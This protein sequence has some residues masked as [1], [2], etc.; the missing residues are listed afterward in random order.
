MKLKQTFLIYKWLFLSLLLLL[1]IQFSFADDD[2]DDDDYEDDEDDYEDDDDDYEDVDD[3][4]DSSSAASSLG[5]PGGAAAIGIFAVAGVIFLGICYQKKRTQRR[6]IFERT[7]NYNN[8]FAARANR[9]K[10]VP[11]AKHS[12]LL[13]KQ[14][15]RNSEISI[16]VTEPGDYIGHR[17]VR[18]QPRGHH[19]K[20][21]L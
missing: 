5:G 10:Q 16:P 1:N 8:A 14:F 20:P 12:N 13:Y 18:T 21:S 2:D 7:N 4:G 19:M 6:D 3:G 15:R 9:A 17:D 11:S